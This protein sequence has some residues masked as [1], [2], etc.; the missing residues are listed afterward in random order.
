MAES[1]IVDKKIIRSGPG[2]NLG[3]YLSGLTTFVNN[4]YLV[5]CIKK[6][7]SPLG[8]SFRENLYRLRLLALSHRLRRMSMQDS[9]GIISSML[10]VDKEILYRKIDKLINDDLKECRCIV[11]N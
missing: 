10:V 7:T 8:Y 11:R 6:C 9:T 1:K 4:V 2:S 5:I 3:E